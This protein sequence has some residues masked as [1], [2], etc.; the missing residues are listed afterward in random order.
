MKKYI[1]LL[2]FSISA[3]SQA[4]SVAVA[5]TLPNDRISALHIYLDCT[6]CDMDYYRTNFT[7]V[8]YVNDSRDADVHILVS[9]LPT[10][11]GGSEYHI[12]MVGQGRY[13]FLTDT[14]VFSLQQDATADEARAAL[15]GRIQ[16]GLVPYLLKTAY[17]DK[18]NLVIDESPVIISEDDPWKSWVFDISGSGSFSSQRALQNLSLGGSLYMSKVTPEIKIESCNSFSYYE[19]VMRQYDGDSLTDT[20]KYNAKDFSSLNFFVKS[21]GNHGGIGGSVSLKKSE[22]NNLNLQ[23]IIGPSAEYNLFSY[24][25]ASSRQ[26]RITYTLC[27]EQTYYRTLTVY[28]K[29]NDYLFRQYLAINFLYFKP[30]GTI[31]AYAG[32]SSYINDLSQYSLEANAVAYIRLFKGLS[33]NISG[34]FSYTNDQRSLRQE[35]ATTDVFLTRQWEMKRDFSYSAMIGLSYRFGSMNNNSVNPRFGT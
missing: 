29:M 7:I 8:N 27:Y 9:M 16:L 4:Y 17:G 20:Y 30:W 14:L 23:M 6:E 24:E 3:V 19:Q 35:P 5:D 11:S 21:L 12:V 22:Y 33:F 32:G 31:S 10:G 1:F 18:L 28:G 34:S 15:L 2:L 26:F 25:D 13:R